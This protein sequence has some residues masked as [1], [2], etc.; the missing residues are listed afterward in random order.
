LQDPSEIKV[1][2]L[3][4]VRHKVSRHFRNEKREYLKERIN[5]VATNSNGNIISDMYRSI[6][7]FK[8]GHQL[9]T[10]GKRTKRVNC[11]QIPKTFQTYERV[12]NVVF[13]DVTPCGSFKNRRFGGI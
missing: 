4:N 2:N 7:E 8:R 5:E 13:W 9:I 6:N 12:K 11:F 1:N 10:K 3:N